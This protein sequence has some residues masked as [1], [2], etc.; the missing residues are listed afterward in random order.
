MAE[1]AGV[2]LGKAV[3]VIVAMAVLHSSAAILRRAAEACQGPAGAGDLIQ[4]HRAPGL[5][6][7]SSWTTPGGIP[8]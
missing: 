1:R 2:V 6:P 4:P 8:S 3:L 7:E 5:L